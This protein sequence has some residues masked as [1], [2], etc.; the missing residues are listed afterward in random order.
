M[1]K[2]F[3]EVIFEVFVEYIEKIIELNTEN[4]N[5]VMV[6]R[7]VERDI[8]FVLVDCKSAYDKMFEILN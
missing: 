6:L 3:I 2:K 4:R 5:I 7:K 1:K 8:E